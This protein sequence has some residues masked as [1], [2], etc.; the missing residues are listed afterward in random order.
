MRTIE[1]GKVETRV[2]MEGRRGRNERDR[3]SKMKMC[4][5][6]EKRDVKAGT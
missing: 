2:R 4:K 6:V 1:R 5:G 3:E